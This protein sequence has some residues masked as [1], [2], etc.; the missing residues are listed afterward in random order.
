MLELKY[1]KGVYKMK[2]TV[3][4]L[5]VT[6]L[7]LISLT[8]FASAEDK[9]GI[10]KVTDSSGETVATYEIVTNN[11]SL[12]ARDTI[13]KALR[14]ARDNAYATNIH[15]VKLPA[16]E[17]CLYQSLNLY[18]NTV[19]DLSGSVIT[20][21]QGCGSMIRFGTSKDVV[22]GYEGYQNITIKNGTFDA[23]NIGGSSLVRFA[24]ASNVE[25]NGV[26]FKNTTD[27]N[28]LL[29]FAACENV[30]IRDCQF[31]DMKITGNLDGFNCE[32]VQIDILKEGYFTY[33]AY[34]GTPT[35]NVSVT[36]CTFEN[37][38]RG[39]GTHSAIAGYYFDNMVFNNNTFKNIESYAVRV[40]NYINSTISDNTIIDCGSGI[41]CGTVT[42]GALSNFFAPLSGM[43]VR[44]EVNVTISGN[45]ISLKSNGA[46]TSSFG[47]R[48]IGKNISSFKDK[49]GNTFTGDCRIS[50][51][52]VE[53]NTV[54]GAITHTSFNAIHIN[55]AK[56]SAYGK[57][58]NVVIKNNKV[59]FGYNGKISNTVYGIKTENSENIYFYGNTVTD[60]KAVIHSSLTADKNTG[61]YFEKNTLSGAKSFGVKLQNIKKA[62]VISNSISNTKSNGIYILNG[63]TSVDVKSNK[64]K[65]C[66]GYGI[67][68]KDGQVNSISSNSIYACKK[69]SLYLTG[70]AK[71]KTVSSNYIC[72]GKKTG[73]Y[74]NKTASATTVT[75]NSID[76]V[77]KSVDGICVN[78]KASVTNITSNKINAKTKKDSKK[79]KV[80]CK[81]GIRINSAFCKIKKI[82]GNTINQCDNTG[83]YIAKAKTKATVSK[84]TVKKAKYGIIYKKSKA[85]L[86][87]NTFKSCSKAKTKV[88]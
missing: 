32:A 86:S 87:K 65:S 84:N 55:G 63:C 69:Y 8:M 81:Y 62:A 22:Y 13:E 40:V 66:S 39:L 83:I 47:I 30:R 35:K 57:K 27:V 42:N 25:I 54:T 29:T 71:V 76:V 36:G 7:M 59:T 45:K 2:K 33:P 26:T 72:G 58:S 38:P 75:K 10:I 23:Q 1:N 18:S 28:H 56:G 4:V 60:K 68:V 80:K 73:I 9:V 64:I 17:Y 49:N 15:T 61:L 50:G 85:K 88:I 14:Y 24:H 82:T 34:D 16:G 79:L 31:R 12:D 44:S 46:D 53:N 77:S 52:R 11:L 78:D 19:L 70:K 20:R 6:V 5:T 3:F 51:V 74:L 48:L 37:V 41:S 21:A 67:D 43:K